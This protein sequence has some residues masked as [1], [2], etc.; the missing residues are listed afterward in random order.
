M[1]GSNPFDDIE[2]MFNRMSRQYAIKNMVDEMSQ[3][4][5]AFDPARFG[6]DPSERRQDS[7]ER[8]DDREQIPVDVY[9]EGDQ[10]RVAIDLPGFA[11]DDITIRLRNETK[12]F[13]S[14]RPDTD[15]DTVGTPIRRE[16]RRE[17]VHRTIS[18]PEPVDNEHTDATYENGVLTVALTKLAASG[19]GKT[20]PIN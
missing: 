14:A 20:I 17:S 13:I 12:L 10:Y 9:D 4:L 3:Q 16:R 18:L 11:T 7:G 2:R 15:G 8:D 1:T 6:L 5:D 19:D